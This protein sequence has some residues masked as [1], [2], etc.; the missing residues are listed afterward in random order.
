MTEIKI[1]KDQA[2]NAYKE[3]LLIR[4]FEERCGQEYSMGSIGG[5]CHL[6]IGQ[7]AI[8]AATNLAKQ[9]GDKTITAYRCHGHALASGLTPVEVMAELMGKKSG[10]SKGKGGSMHIFNPKGGYYGGHG[11]VGAQIPLGTGIAFAEKYKN[12]GNICYSFMGDGAVHQGQVYEVFNMASLWN[13]PVLYIIEN[14][15]YAMGT[16]VNRSTTNTDLYNRGKSFGIQGAIC[17]AMDIEKTYTALLNASE[18]VRCGKG[19]FLLELKTYRYRGHSVSD[20]AKYRSKDEVEQYKNL[21]SIEHLSQLIIERKYLDAN[22]LNKIQD[23]IK[24]TVAQALQIAKA[25]SEPN[26]EEL[27]TDVFSVA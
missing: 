16:S 7:E 11:I 3:M 18:Y 26:H 22:E 6:Y 20:P 24:N 27:Y 1:T 19:P 13:L 23:D 10:S 25:D 8:I 14:N 21:D 12:T 9:K 17:D 15:G 4:R 2:I 5:F